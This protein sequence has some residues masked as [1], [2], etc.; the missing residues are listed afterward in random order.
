[1]RIDQQRYQAAVADRRSDDQIRQS[2]DAEALQREFVQRLGVVDRD[3][4]SHGN[5]AQAVGAAKWPFTLPWDARYRQTVVEGEILR[6]AR[7]AVLRQIGGRGRDD[8]LEFADAARGKVRLAQRTYADRD[9]DSGLDEID[10]VLTDDEV[11]RDIRVPAGEVRQRRHHRIRGE[12][13]A[14]PHAHPS[15]RLAREPH[16]VRLQVG[17]LADDPLYAL[18]VD[19]TLGG[20]RQLAGRSLQEPHPEP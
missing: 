18:E 19:L 1:M 20:Q 16:Y 8:A 15:A 5:Q 4:A 9:V 12:R 11:Q 7:H 2:N 3:V 13:G 17:D 14:D 6:L 10:F